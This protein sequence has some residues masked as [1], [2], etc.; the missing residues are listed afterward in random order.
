MGA[1]ESK[2]SALPAPAKP[3]P[4]RLLVPGEFLPTPQPFGPYF[5]L[6]E[7]GKGSFGVAFLAVLAADFALVAGEPLP[8]CRELFTTAKQ[9]FVAKRFRVVL[10]PADVPKLSDDEKNSKTAAQIAAEEAKLLDQQVATFK[11]LFADELKR[12]TALKTVIPKHEHIVQFI[13]SVADAESKTDAMVFEYCN[14]GDIRSMLKRC[15]DDDKKPRFLTPFEALH[16]AVQL[17]D[18]LAALHEHRIVHR[19]LNLRNFFVH[20]TNG[21]PMLKIGDFGF[22]IN[23]NQEAAPTESNKNGLHQP[24]G[25]DGTLKHPWDEK[26]DI[27]CLGIVFYE[28]L[29]LIDLSRNTLYARN[30]TSSTADYIRP[31]LVSHLAALEDR[32]AG[33]TDIIPKMIDDDPAKRPAAKAVVDSLRDILSQHARGRHALFVISHF[34][35]AQFRPWLSEVGRAF[36]PECTVKRNKIVWMHSNSSFTIVAR[37]PLGHERVS[38]GDRFV[39]QLRDTEGELKLLTKAMVGTLSGISCDPLARTR[40][41]F[42]WAALPSRTARSPSWRLKTLLHGNHVGKGGVILRVT[43]AFTRSRVTTWRCMISLGICFGVGHWTTLTSCASHAVAT[44][45]VWQPMLTRNLSWFCVN[46]MARSFANGRSGTMCDKLQ[47]TPNRTKSWCSPKSASVCTAPTANC[48]EN[49]A[50]PEAAMGSSNMQPILQLTSVGSFTSAT[51]KRAMF[52]CSLGT[53][54]SF[55]LG[56]LIASRSRLR[57]L[58]ILCLLLVGRCSIRLSPKKWRFSIALDT[59]LARWA[60]IM[61]TE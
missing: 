33:V 25:V 30:T 51:T 42:L 50:K 20:F 49:G 47:W 19:D 6:M 55:A 21:V 46:P 16:L 38:G 26:G 14:G 37:D 8:S 56:P 18:G 59:V 36:A 43:E 35:P 11:A 34:V 39:V 40:R 13:G 27:Y 23:L 3:P 1:S 28:L 10:D 52:K 9:H 12:A 7:I 45:S 41:L 54:R 31:F 2:D 53:E 22:C 24:P 4:P 57:S 32:F 15:E 29:S 48:W 44:W 58:A 17:A 61:V 5:L 60:I